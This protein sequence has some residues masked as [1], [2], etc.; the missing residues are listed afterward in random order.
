MEFP[1]KKSVGANVYLPQE[2]NYGAPKICVFEI[3]QCTTMRK[4]ILELYV[5]KIILIT[6]NTLN[7]SCSE[8][9]FLQK[10]WWAH[11]SISPRSG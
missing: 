2:C 9:N 7:K 3:W 5:A 1:T 6:K 11:M 8:L 4:F 10:S